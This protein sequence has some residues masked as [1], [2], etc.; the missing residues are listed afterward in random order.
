MPVLHRDFIH[1][2]ITPEREAQPTCPALNSSG[3]EEADISLLNLLLIAKGQCLNGTGQ[4]PHLV[5]EPV[6][7]IEGL[8]VLPSDC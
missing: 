7:I 2:S 3:K 6:Q 1:R 5:V 4:A 8:N